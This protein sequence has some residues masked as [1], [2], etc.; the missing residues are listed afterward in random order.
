MILA[1][2]CLSVLLQPDDRAQQKVVEN[3]SPLARYAAEHWVS[4]AQFEGVISRL[5]KEIKYLFDPDKPYFTAWIRLHDVDTELNNS[6]STLFNIRDSKSDAAPLYYAARCGFHDLV[7]HLIDKY[8]QHVNATGGRFITPF[9]AALARRHFQV[10]QLLHRNG[11]SV[12]P[13]GFCELTPLMSAAC[14]G[15]IEMVEVLLN[16]KA[17]IKAQDIHGCTALHCAA[18]CGLPSAPEV[19]RLLLKRGADINACRTDLATPL[20][21]AAR[22]DVVRVL[23]EHGASVDGKD[24]KGQ[25]AFQVAQTDEIKKLLS[26]H[27]AKNTVTLQSIR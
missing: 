8:P 27:S 13:R 9:V 6:D 12:G 18:E 20:H 16:Y 25:T 21:E 11:S 1:Q 26:K 14:L 5:R 3:S 23:L 15:D 2:A 4:H 19:V 24:D 10:A 7:E 22:F 17:D